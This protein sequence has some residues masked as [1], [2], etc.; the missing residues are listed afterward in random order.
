[1]Q[2]NAMYNASGTSVHIGFPMEEAVWRTNHG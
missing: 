1:M 2:A